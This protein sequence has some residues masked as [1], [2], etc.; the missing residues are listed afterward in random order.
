MQRKISVLITVL[1]IALVFGVSGA[2]AFRGGGGTAPAVEIKSKVF[3]EAE[4]DKMARTTAVIKTGFG[5][6]KVMFFPDLA[7]N[8]VDNFIQLAKSGFYDKT[9]FHRVIPGFMIQGGDPKTKNH[10]RAGH[11]TGGPGYYMKAEFSGKPHKRGILSMARSQSPDSGG[12]QFYVCVA[13]ASWLD[14]KY[15]VF[16][17]VVS[18]MNVVDR[19]VKQPRDSRD[20]PL[21][22]IEIKLL[23]K[24]PEEEKLPAKVDDVDKADDGAGKVDEKKNEPAKK[25]A[26][27]IKPLEIRELEK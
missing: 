3:S 8:H 4:I 5:D 24:E 20:N 14:R 7:P 17:K 16:G 18:G 11:G 1:S 26:T 13:D 12:S 22:R 9:I 10:N 2:D 15:T 23:I 27:E 19:I 21:E 25:P 6:I